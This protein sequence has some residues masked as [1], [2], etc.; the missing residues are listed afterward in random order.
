M[1]REDKATYYVY[2][3]IDPRN[4]EEFYYGKGSGNRKSAHLSDNSDTEKTK[5]IKAI[6]NEGLEPIIKVIAKDLTEKEAFLIEKTLIWKLGKSLLNI[7]SGQFADKFRK[8]DSFHLDLTGF[9]FNNGI[10]YVNV[11]QG[12]NR[13][14][15]DCK[16][17]GFLSAGQD[18]K[19]SDPIRTLESGDIIVAYL[20]GYGYVGIGRVIEK[21]VKVND[22]KI[23]GKLLHH[24]NLKESNIFEN[25]DNEKSEY[26]VKVDWIKSVE[27]KDAK[28]KSK[29]GLFT[30]Q[31]I[32]ANL[33][34][35]K[36]TI[37]FLET[38]F[39]IKFRDLLLV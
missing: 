34:G 17:F 27:S 36:A 13:S 9:D 25:C 5:R 22:F 4:F 31:L 32:K 2:V 12:N 1:T 18:K 26:L 33:Q 10:Y 21:A 23:D 28:W 6:K 20:K 24:F 39:N 38:E 8:H 3:Y 16:Q 35:Q 29:A 19:W 7:S 14:W 15:A 11:G 37:D 30:I